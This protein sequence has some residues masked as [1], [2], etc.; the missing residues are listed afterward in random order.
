MNR[1][2]PKRKCPSC[3]QLMG[4]RMTWMK[5]DE[6]LFHG[7]VHSHYRAVCPKCEKI[8]CFVEGC[9]Q[10]ASLFIEHNVYIKH[11]AGAKGTLFRNDSFVCSKHYRLIAAYQKIMT[12]GMV[13]ITLTGIVT[14]I[15]SLA[16]KGPLVFVAIAMGI[17]TSLVYLA[18][19]LYRRSKR[20]VKKKKFAVA[21]VGHFQ[22]LPDLGFD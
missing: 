20:V 14:I 12:A 3:G 4:W 21:E 19:F 22:T 1:E 8:E 13:G 10:K 9:D 16:G 2:L 6:K 15:A 11:T 18:A 7:K 17:L 5:P